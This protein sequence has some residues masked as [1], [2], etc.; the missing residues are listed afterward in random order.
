[1]EKAAYQVYYVEFA[2]FMHMIY[3]LEMNEI[4]NDLYFNEYE[5]FLDS[6]DNPLNLS[7]DDCK[8]IMSIDLE[9]T[10]TV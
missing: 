10:V 2:C 9:S 3:N 6:L 7:L 8:Y 4:N 1:M 5:E